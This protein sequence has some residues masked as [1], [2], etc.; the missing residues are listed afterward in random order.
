MLLRRRSSLFAVGRGEAEDT[1]DS[2]ES[3]TERILPRTPVYPRVSSRVGDETERPVS[4]ADRVMRVLRDRRFHSVSEL[5]RTISFQEILVGLRDLISLGHAFDRVGR[6]FRIRRRLNTEVP[7]SMA[8]L[9]VGIEAT[10]DKLDEELE[11][12]AVVVDSVSV[13]EDVESPDFDPSVD[14]APIESEETGM[15]LSDP[16]SALTLPDHFLHSMALAILAKR[17]SGKTYLGMV[18]VEEIL[19]LSSPPS[20][21]VFDPNGA[22]WGLCATAGGAPADHE[23]LLLGGPRGH[24]PIGVKDGARLAELSCEMAPGTIVVDLSELAPSEQHEVVADFCERLLG[25]PRYQ[26]HVVF[27]EADEFAPQRLGGLST[28]QKRSLGF[29]ERL[30]MRGRSRGIGTTLISLRPAVLA[31]NVLSQVDALCLLRMVEPNDLRAV[32]EWL[33]NFEIGVTAE[34]RSQCLG[35]LPVLSV[36]TAYFLRGGDEIMFRRFKVRQ[37]RTFDSSRT[38]DGG[39]I[40]PA[41]LRIPGPGIMTTAR[42]IL[43]AAP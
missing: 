34:Q 11:K 7:Q 23:I 8:G 14:S 24:L 12:K 37:K 15:I 41:T 36:G 18:L 6:N 31:K 30:V 17:G 13:V 29:V 19:G 35:L 27:D 28:H 2:G 5:E 10:C 33:E 43:K 25:L 9:T 32:R 26:L 42:K 38:P 40:V 20:V 4:P 3:K 39:L 16:P 22:W 1:G 21:V